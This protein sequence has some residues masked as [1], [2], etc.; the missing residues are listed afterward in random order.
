M[1]DQPPPINGPLA[2]LYGRLYQF[3]IFR[4]AFLAYLLS[5]TALL[6]IKVT[7]LS[8]E[9]EWLNDCVAHGLY[10]AIMCV[11]AATLAPSPEALVVQGF[12]GG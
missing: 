1:S 2:V 12:D 4:W 3:Q 10:L 5:P 6:I 11:I 9:Y 8:W 7:V